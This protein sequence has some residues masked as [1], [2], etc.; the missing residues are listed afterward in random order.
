ML[1]INEKEF[2]TSCLRAGH[3]K[4]GTSLSD[5]DAIDK[6]MRAD[7]RGLLEYRRMQMQLRRTV[8]SNT[9]MTTNIK[10]Q[11]EC[12]LQLGRTRVLAVVSGDVLP[13]FPDRPTEGF[14]Q[15]NVELSPMAAHTFENKQS[16]K[17]FAAELSRIVERAIRDCKALDTE[18]LAII[19]GESVWAIKCTV[20]V[21]DFSR[22]RILGCNRCYDAF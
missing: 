5:M 2:L 17:A 18:A 3:G 14:L 6:R 19:A 20:H 4:F 12:E 11:S 22:C 8:P 1:S 10:P 9:F 7:G 15:F 21:L 13:P 16:H